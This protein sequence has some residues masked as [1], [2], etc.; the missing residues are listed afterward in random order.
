[1]GFDLASLETAR[2]KQE[3]GVTVA[4]KHPATGAELGITITIASYESE[5][6]KRVAREMANKALLEQKR[7]PKKGETVEAIEERAMNIAIAA[8]LDWQGIEMDGK[9]F[10]FNRENAR[11]LLEKFPFI[12]E[13]LDSAAGDRSLFFG[14]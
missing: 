2:K 9:P 5:R 8:I 1:M 14:N 11:M 13:Q 7:N 6:V 10:P 12:G 3:E 4:I